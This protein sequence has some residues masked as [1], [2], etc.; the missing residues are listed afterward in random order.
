[1]A[2]KGKYDLNTLLLKEEDTQQFENLKST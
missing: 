2:A 1:M